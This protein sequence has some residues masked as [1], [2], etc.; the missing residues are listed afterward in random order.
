[1]Q[2]QLRKPTRT[3]LWRIES[4]LVRFQ[5]TSCRGRGATPRLAPTFLLSRRP[6]EK[7]PTLSSSCSWMCFQSEPG[8]SASSETQAL[9]RNL[10]LHGIRSTVDGRHS[11]CSS[12]PTT[13]GHS[14]RTTSKLSAASRSLTSS[15]AATS[16]SR[17]GHGSFLLR[18]TLNSN[19]RPTPQAYSS[20]SS[21]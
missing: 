16:S 11:L 9:V 3:R 4:Q 5:L 21:T 12:C 15:R 18:M 7:S 20:F 19:A 6:K 14:L 13:R 17:S 1:M 8:L 10:C 2:L